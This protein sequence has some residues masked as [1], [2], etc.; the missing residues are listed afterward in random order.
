MLLCCDGNKNNKSGGRSKNVHRLTYCDVKKGDRI[1]SKNPSRISDNMDELIFY[2]LNGKI[3][4]HDPVFNDELNS[5]LNL[6]HFILAEK[7]KV[8]IELVGVFFNQALE[9]LVGND[10]LVEVERQIK[11]WEVK[12]DDRTYPGSFRPYNHI[13][14]FWLKFLLEQVTT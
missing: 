13:A 5:V 6:N 2:D 7:R 14:I 10:L 1:L 3:H 11:W 12:N 8:I 9:T 4:S